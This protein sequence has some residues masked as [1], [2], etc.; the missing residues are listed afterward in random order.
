MLVS[1]CVVKILQ[2]I[3]HQEVVCM[4]STSWQMSG[5][6]V[7][8]ICWPDCPVDMSASWFADMLADSVGHKENILKFCRKSRRSWLCHN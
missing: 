6:H 3:C 4:L 8:K 5:R 2:M 1:C 7:V